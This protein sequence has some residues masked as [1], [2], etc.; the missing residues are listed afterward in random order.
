MRTRPTGFPILGLLAL[1]LGG[2]ASARAQTPAPSCEP[3]P[4]VQ[5][6]LRNLPESTG[7]AKADRIARIEALRE[8]LDRYPDDLFVHQRYQDTAASTEKDRDA[9]IAEYRT[10][11]QQQ[12]AN[13]LYAYLAAR[14]Q[15][16]VNTRQVIPD[17]ERLSADFPSGHL[18]LVRIFQSSNFKDEKRA[19]EHLQAFTA[20]CPSSLQA[21]DYFRSLE[22]SDF[23]R[24]GV[25]RLRALLQDRTD[26]DL[27]SY[28]STLWNLE[29]RV[30][31]TGEHDAVRKQLVEDLK[32]LRAIDPGRNR[33][34]YSTLQQGYKLTSDMEGDKWV[35]DE[36]VRLFPSSAVGTVRSHWHEQNPYPKENDP[37]DKHRA[38]NDAQAEASAEWVRLAPQY[39]SAWLDR[40]QA[41]RAVEQADP[42]DVETAGE[43]LLKTRARNPSEF[44]FMSTVGANSC[45]LVVADLFANKGVRL[46]RLP[47]LVKQGIAELD[48]STTLG[49]RSDLYSRPAAP[50]DDNREFRYWYGWQT[51]TDIWLKVGDKDRTRQALEQLLVLMEKYKPRPDSNDA[52]LAAR[53]RAHMSRQVG[54]WQRM[55]DLAQ[56][57]GRPKID[58]MTFY[59][60][61]LLARASPPAGTAKDELAEKA[62][63]L[64][65]EMGGS[66]EGWQ[67]WMSR[68]ELLGL[69]IPSASAA[70][71]TK[72]EKSLPEFELADMTGATWRLA[73]LKG[74]TTLIGMWATW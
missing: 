55:G 37:P 49:M 40:V 73:D 14:A 72:M 41:L 5:Q 69:A 32:R 10:L 58:A 24:Q 20:S 25:E 22:P 63:A 64:W 2:F 45:S 36:I 30:K 11:L 43:N 67:A 17:L 3:S 35:R 65:N 1:A 7:D 68:K 70:A 12:P 66:N 59:Q 44:S 27:L 53:Q 47:E 48:E 21:F 29:F 57:E 62:H 38:Y 8:L 16:G 51:I 4:A 9:V 15:V 13:K 42:G 33:S 28:Y 56:L 54:Y 6:A 19:I 31:P 23:V 60:N 34:F 18:L 52:K 26:P 71:W 39:S 74:K 46:D 50:E 61:A